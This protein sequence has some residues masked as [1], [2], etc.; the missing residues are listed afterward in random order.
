MEQQKIVADQTDTPEFKST[1]V[2]VTILLS[3]ITMGIYM[4]YWFLTR[5]K[6]LN[7]IDPEKKVSFEFPL[8]VLILY[9]LSAL[10]TVLYLILPFSE[11]FV[12]TIDGLD[13]IITFYG[14]TVM[15]ILSFRAVSLLKSY[16]SSIPVSKLATFFFTI[17]YVQYK[18]NKH[19]TSR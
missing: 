15:V 14:V 16:D 2:I 17:W 10:F 5:R 8:S 13:R 9:S 4:P 11:G 18:I 7:K 12:A 19:F 6:E 1:P 3:L